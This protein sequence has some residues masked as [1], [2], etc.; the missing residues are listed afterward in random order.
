MKCIICK[1]GEAVVPDRN[2]T[3]NFKAKK[4]ICSQCHGKRL[5]EDFKKIEQSHNELRRRHGC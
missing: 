1:K 5:Q 4:E 3:Q 2:K